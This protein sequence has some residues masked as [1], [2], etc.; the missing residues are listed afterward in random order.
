MSG[1]LGATLTATARPRGHIFLSD[2]EA[3]L[4]KIPTA[5]IDA[6]VT[7]PPYGL[8]SYQPTGDEIDAYLAG[9]TLDTGGDFMGKDWSIPPVG[10]WRECL[11]V[12]KPG[13]V[14]LSFAGTR[15]WDLIATGIEQAGFVPHPSLGMPILAWIHGQG[16]PKSVNVAKAIDKSLGVVSGDGEPVSDQAK[17]WQ[18]WGTALKPSWE[19]IL[20]YVKPGAPPPELSVRAPFFYSPKVKR[21][22]A[23]LDGRI[24]N[25]HPTRKPLALMRWLVSL[26][27]PANG[28]VLD[29]Y[30]GSGTTCAAAVL[31][32]RRYV[33]IE[34]DPAYHKIATERLRI[35]EEDMARGELPPTP[36]NAHR[37][38]RGRRASTP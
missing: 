1:A 26:A 22:E 6:I 31:E 4:P 18:G 35:I 5:E 3:I 33:G 36:G 9:A 14:L 8:G 24:V 25:N 11:R 37:S 28:V 15:T 13:G 38:A 2:G 16:F 21:R 34:R 29:P 12:L 30:V 17:Q 19:P 27:V 10:I 7:D 23:T 32:G 20:V